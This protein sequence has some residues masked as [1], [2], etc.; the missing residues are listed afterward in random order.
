MRHTMNAVVTEAGEILTQSL[1]VR[2]RHPSGHHLHL[3]QI[4]LEIISRIFEG[5]R[6]DARAGQ[7]FDR[8]PSSS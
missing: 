3:Q 4:A 5:R 8:G 1:P 6:A 2:V 7:E